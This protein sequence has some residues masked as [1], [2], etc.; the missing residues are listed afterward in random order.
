[1]TGDPLLD[2]LRLELGDALVAGCLAADVTVEVRRDEIAHA[3]AILRGRFRYTSLADLCGA[4]YPWREQ[5]FEVIYH[6]YSFREN[7]R[8]RVKVL[9]GASS[10][11]PSVSAVW[12]G[13]DWL[14]R[15]IHDLFG[16]V[17]SGRP[18]LR[19]LLLWK[20]FAG[21]PLRK[22][23]PLAGLPAAGAAAAA[24]AA[25]PGPPASSPAATASEPPGDT[26]A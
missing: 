10:P 16:I 25:A 3:A 18:E 1:V 5:R 24:V 17:F 11:V 8:I 15:E 9:T 19:P 23:F 2:E 4:D 20:G 6:L 7:R 14:E 22:D 26:P 21:H 12:P 13:A